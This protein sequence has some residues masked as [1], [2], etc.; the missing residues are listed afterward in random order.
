MYSILK[1]GVRTQPFIQL[2]ILLYVEICA[3]IFTQENEYINDKRDIFRL[4]SYAHTYII[5]FQ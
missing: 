5:I 2:C 1:F 4:F 3:Q